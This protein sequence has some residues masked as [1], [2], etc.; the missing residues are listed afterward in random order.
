MGHN[1]DVLPQGEEGRAAAAA[2]PHGSELITAHLQGI[3][4]NRALSKSKSD[5]GHLLVLNLL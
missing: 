3:S 1:A 4:P 2:K 5:R